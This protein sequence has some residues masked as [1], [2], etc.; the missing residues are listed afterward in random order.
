MAVSPLV[1]RAPTPSQVHPHAHLAQQVIPA[2][3]TQCQWLAI[4]AKRSMALTAALAAPALKSV[5]THQ[6]RQLVLAVK[7]E[8]TRLG[9]HLALPVRLAVAAPNRAPVLQA[10]PQ[11]SVST[12]API[13]QLWSSLQARFS[14]HRAP[15]IPILS[16]AISKS[17]KS[18][19][20]EKLARIQAPSPL[21]LCQSRPT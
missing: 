10:N 2:P 17:V 1:A 14:R 19:L 8:S 3:P 9:A 6:H 21:V 20:L 11:N 5:Q 18:A 12:L 7:S 4:P 13:P 16:A 15:P